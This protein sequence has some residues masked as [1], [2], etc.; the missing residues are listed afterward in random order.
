MVLPDFRSLGVMLRALLLA[1]GLRFVLAYVALGNLSEVI[2]SV[3]RWA[4]IFEPAL[5]TVLAGLFLASRPL[6][7]LPYRLGAAAVALL[8]ALCGVF[9]RYLYATQFTDMA[10]PSPVRVA[11]TALT[12]AV[13]IL[14]YF[15]WRHRVL[16][17]A[18]S[19]A[20]LMALQAR[21]R[22]HFLFNSLNTV[23]GL[24]R[25]EPRRAETVL[26]N[27]SE[28]FRASMAEASALAPL[29]KELELAR[30]YA[31][32][33]AVRLGGRLT[34][35]WQC[36]NAPLDAL[37][38][39]LILQ[40]LLENAVYHGIE[41]AAGGG[42]VS[43]TI[44]VRGDQLNLVVRNP[45]HHLRERR[46]GN[47]MALENIRERLDLHFDAEAALRA[48]ESGDEFVVQIRMPYRRAAS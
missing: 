36:Q 7:G 6:S 31:E 13:G 10:V 43:V 34:V 11:F 3:I 29:A 32:I 40:P 20:R 21:I 15:N 41:P 30:S 1:E 8:A 16:S 47:R 5:L 48:Y 4:G 18:L 42:T 14:F 35:D 45:V 38:P 28:L 2:E 39:P 25:S 19:E 33:E 24:M 37:V 12:L 23:L 44:F 22:P 46:S 17:P 27:L 9:W 26:E